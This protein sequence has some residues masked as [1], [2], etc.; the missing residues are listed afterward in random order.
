M[1]KYE[2]VAKQIEQYITDNQLSQGDKLPILDELTEQ[3]KVSKS[4]IIKALD[5]LELRGMIYQVRGSGIF[6]RQ[7]KRKGYINMAESRGFKESLRE[8]DLTSKVMA[9][10]LI[11]P[12]SHL[13]EQLDLEEDDEVYLVKRVRYIEESPF[14]IEYSYYS[15]KHVMYLNQEIA[16]DSIFTYI[17]NDLKLNIGFSDTFF[18]ISYLNEGEAG[19]LELKENDPALRVETTYYLHNGQPFNYS[20][21]LYHKDQAQFFV[22]GTHY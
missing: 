12:D 5:I 20:I 15:K 7:Q 19:H 18:R 13:M 17:M 9:L 16:E 4:T 21:L 11:K 3:F 1:L 8:F 10:K 2:K 22:P 6:V 14:C